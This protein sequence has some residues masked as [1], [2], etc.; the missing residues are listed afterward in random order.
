MFALD[1][2]AWV[3]LNKLFILS[4]LAYCPHLPYRAKQ[5]RTKFSSDKIFVPYEKF[6]HFSPT[7]HFVH[8]RNLKL[9]QKRFNLFIFLEI[10]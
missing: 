10:I 4:P 8:F 1:Y 7:K 6:R 9:A 3:L 5:C 2:F